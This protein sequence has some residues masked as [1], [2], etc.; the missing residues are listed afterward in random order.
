MIPVVVAVAVAVGHLLVAGA[1]VDVD[2]HRVFLRR[3]TLV[4]AFRC[5]GVV[6][7]LRALAGLEASKLLALS[8]VVEHLAL[9]LAVVLQ[10]F[11]QRA[12][13]VVQCIDRRHVGI[14]VGADVVF[15][16]VA[17]SGVVSA[18]D[19]PV[20]TVAKGVPFVAAFVNVVHLGGLIIEALLLASV[21]V[22]HEEALVDCAMLAA[23]VVEA[24]VLHVDA[25]HVADL[26]VA[27]GHL[28]H[29]L[30]LHVVEVD[31]A[32]AVALASDEHLLLGLLAHAHSDELPGVGHVD[33][34]V[35][36][37][38]VE[39]GVGLTAVL[40]CVDGQYLHVVLQAVHAHEGQRVGIGPLE[41]GQV[42]PF[43]TRRCPHRVLFPG[44]L[45]ILCL[46]ALQLVDAQAHLAVIFAGLGVLVAVVLGIEGSPHLHIVLLHLAL[47][48][49]QVGNLL[50]VGAP[51]EPFGDG[52]L[53]LVHPV[54][55]AVDHL[56]HLAVGG[57][58][59]LLKGAE[60][61]PVEVV[62]AHKGH[63]GAVGAEG[64]EALLAVLRQLGE[65]TLLDVV[66]P[67]VAHAAV[68]VEWLE[69]TAQ[70]YP[71]LVLAHLVPLHRR[72]G[73]GL[74][75]HGG[76]A[77]E[78]HVLHLLAGD[79]AVFGYAGARHAEV[80]LAVGHRTQRA[81]AARAESALRPD[82]LQGYILVLG[83]GHTHARE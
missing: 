12:A 33:I 8:A 46:S 78:A 67:V 63:L 56:V 31:V 80:V 5:D 6:V 15:A 11:H 43:T 59:V 54:G 52:E 1:A 66:Q 38:V 10:H 4:K 35:V 20:R 77:E 34:G 81:D 53:L 25:G 58:L 24:L 79:I 16:A 30:A 74:L 19:K 27:A 45:G 51:L 61:H 2:K 21:E 32:V 76:T 75:L 62:V 23:G 69:A 39:G 48:E 73:L 29:Q 55:G 60:V 57:N 18:L 47:V 64:S 70:Q 17:E 9:Q 50:R 71:L 72:Q 14:A 37:L 13:R 28:L 26:P 49:A 36:L 22:Y 3:I 65:R 40:V 44:Q 42:F 83:S 41:A 7:Q 68:A 82:V